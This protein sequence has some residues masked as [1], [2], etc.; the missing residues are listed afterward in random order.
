MSRRENIKAKMYLFIE[1]KL[2]TFELT[3]EIAKNYEIDLL[4]ILEIV[5]KSEKIEA[6]YA[7]EHQFKEGIG[8][9]REEV[10]KSDLEEDFKWQAPIYT[11]EGKNVLGIM[12]FKNHFGIWFFNGA[13]L[14][15]PQNVLESAQDKTKGMRHIKYYDV[16]EID[17]KIIRNYVAEAIENQRLG[18]VLVPAKKKGAKIPAELQLA[19]DKNISIKKKFEEFSPYKQ[20]EFCEYIDSAKQEKTKF[21]R[22]EKILPM[23]EDGIGLHDKYRK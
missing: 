1:P 23:I 10:L 4:F 15:D 11:L 16:D 7:R 22:L 8:K 13:F 2:N 3:Q 14:K 19:L 6:F 18:K 21:S 12:A 5:N 20:R 17:L 9:L